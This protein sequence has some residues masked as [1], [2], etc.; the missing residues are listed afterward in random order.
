[1]RILIGAIVGAIVVFV[2]SAIL[3]MATPLGTSGLS[4]LPNEDQVLEGLRAN[5]QRSG[6][7]M[8]PGLDP[9]T[10]TE[11]QTSAWNAKFQRGPSGLL[12]ISVGAG[13]ALS[14][15]QLILEFLTT[16]VAAWFGALI[17]VRIGGSLLTRALVVAMLPVFAFFSVTASHWIWYGFPSAFVLAELAM[18]VIAWTCAGLAM[19]KIVT[20]ASGNAP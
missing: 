6:L 1:M 4:V 18:E 14:P 16:L 7:Y 10:A 11:A 19:A 15:R 17:L 5:V 20:A 2:V 13:E 8:F 12:L 3:H 9:R